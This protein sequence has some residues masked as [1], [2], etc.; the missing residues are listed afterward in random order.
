M[1]FPVFLQ[2]RSLVELLSTVVLRADVGGG[3][4]GRGARVKVGVAAE[5][6]VAG[7]DGEEGRDILLL[8]IA[9]PENETAGK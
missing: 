6:K 3:R 2:N 7:D 8:E 5:E 4:R 9:S 1:Y